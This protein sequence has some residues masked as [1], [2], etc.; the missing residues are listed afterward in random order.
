MF[1]KLSTQLQ[2]GALKWIT[3]TAFGEKPSEK[4]LPGSYLTFTLPNFDTHQEKKIHNPNHSYLIQILQM[5]LKVWDKFPPSS[6]LIHK[7]LPLMVFKELC[8][9]EVLH[10]LILSLT[11]T[12]LSKK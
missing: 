8:L 5:V 4:S 3:E 2:W 9:Y 7:T 10:N 6:A 1:C 11:Q 12:A